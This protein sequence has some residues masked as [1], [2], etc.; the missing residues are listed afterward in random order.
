MLAE[1]ELAAARALAAAEARAQEVRDSARSEREQILASAGVERARL[2]DQAYAEAAKIRAAALDEVTTFARHLDADR[3][4]LVDQAR[5]EADKIVADAR[6]QVEMQ[7]QADADAKALAERR[8]RPVAAPIDA[9][10]DAPVDTMVAS[11]VDVTPAHPSSDATANTE[12]GCHRRAHHGELAPAGAGVDERQR[13]QQREPRGRGTRN[14]RRHA[15][16]DCRHLAS[17]EA[18]AAPTLQ[19]RALTQRRTGQ[20]LSTYKSVTGVGSNWITSLISIRPSPARV[21]IS[22]TTPSTSSASIS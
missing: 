9:P 14:D 3:R 8:R 6:A 4:Q 18:Q 2:I 22:V 7:A 13:Q 20:S 11:L 21:A 17:T 19:P 16:R 10:I 12:R 15:G 5:A 1:G